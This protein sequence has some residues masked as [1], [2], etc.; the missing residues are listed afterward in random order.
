MHSPLIK[1]GFFVEHKKRKRDEKFCLFGLFVI[2]V[3]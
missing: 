1:S 2:F 3:L